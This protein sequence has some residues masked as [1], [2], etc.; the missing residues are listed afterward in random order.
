MWFEL[1]WVDPAGLSSLCDV[2]CCCPERAPP[3]LS[4]TRSGI[5]LNS[6]HLITTTTLI[7]ISLI[8]LPHTNQQRHHSVSAD[9][10]KLPTALQHTHTYTAGTSLHYPPPTN[11]P[12]PC[13][14]DYPQS[15]IP[16]FVPFNCALFIG[17]LLIFLILLNLSFLWNWRI[18]GF[19]SRR[20][21]GVMTLYTFMLATK[22]GKFNF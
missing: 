12:T 1:F 20:E 13:V 7:F 9:W 18:Y 3:G 6:H 22:K 11:A 4:D 17:S 14:P 5:L 2:L 21:T 16:S 15:S 8:F 19:A 10:H